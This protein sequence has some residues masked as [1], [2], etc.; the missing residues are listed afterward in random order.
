L[1][2]LTNI[3]DISNCSILYTNLGTIALRSNRATD[4]LKLFQK[5]A[6]MC[7]KIGEKYGL[8]LASVGIAESLV[9]LK[10]MDDAE[11]FCKKAVAISKKYS[12]FDL[13]ANAYCIYGLYHHTKGDLKNARF[14]L[15][16]CIKLFER[17][18]LKLQL[19]KAYYLMATV[20]LA[21]KKLDLQK[22]AKTYLEKAYA[23][24]K[25]AGYDGERAV[26]KHIEDILKE[27]IK[28]QP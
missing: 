2:I 23:I 8:A 22:T 26:L 7:E 15:E 14:Y 1:N 28:Y 5:S 17:F 27:T 10:K 18:N 3:G 11:Q 16:E 6:E 19:A 12:Y 13:L 9:G 21:H 24:F 4:A 25:T 20:L